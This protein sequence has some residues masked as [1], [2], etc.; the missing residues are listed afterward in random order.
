MDEA[1]I[2]EYCTY[3]TYFK[4]NN[5][6]NSI[7][8][9]VQSFI[10]DSE[11]TEMSDYIISYNREDLKNRIDALCNMSLKHKQN[12]SLFDFNFDNN[13]IIKTEILS[14]GSLKDFL[15]D[16]GDEYKVSGC[17]DIKTFV[18]GP[19]VSKSLL[20]I[21][22][23]MTPDRDKVRKGHHRH[24]SSGASSFFNTSNILNKTQNI[25]DPVRTK[26]YKKY[27][28]VEAIKRD[29]TMNRNVVLPTKNAVLSLKEG[30]IF[31]LGGRVNDKTCPSFIEFLEE[32]NTL[33]YHPDMV[34]Q[35]E[36]HGV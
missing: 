2:D 12:T 17:R 15:N 27:K 26:L 9:Y 19:D 28:E 4:A 35:R 5:S 36:S 16:D 14:K 25:N 22:M 23:S 18:N 13:R 29:I 8:K 21:S 1:M 32:S 24:T 33:V 20:D 7:Y 6:L 11:A 3:E 10:E 30:R 31:F 34:V